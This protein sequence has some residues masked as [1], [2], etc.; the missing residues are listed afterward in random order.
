MKDWYKFLLG[1]DNIYNSSINLTREFGVFFNTAT[2]D[3]VRGAVILSKVNKNGA[4]IFFSPHAA[5]IAKPLVEKYHAGSCE[6]PIKENDENGHSLSFL[7]GDRVF[8]DQTFPPIQ[9]I[10]VKPENI[11]PKIAEPTTLPDLIKVAQPLLDLYTQSQNEQLKQ[12]LDHDLKVHQILAKQNRTLILFLFII[13]MIILG[14]TSYLYIQNKD[15]SATNLIQLVVA[16]GGAAFGGYGW[17][18]S[19]HSVQDEHK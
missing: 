15:G 1:F 7:A 18:S 17:A 19:K 11:S 3:D 9:S 8:F 13:S 5:Q 14:I 6:I 10:S 16:L 4:M 2:D 12:E